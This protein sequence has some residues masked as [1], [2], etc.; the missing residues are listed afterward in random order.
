MSAPPY[1]KLFWGDYHKATRHLTRDQH[2]AYFLLIGE[3]WRLGGALPD[4]DAKLAAWALCTPEEWTAM[5]PIIMDFFALRRG[6]WW[7]DRVREEL[8]VYE[9]TSRKRKEAGKKG[10]SAK[11]G[12]ITGNQEA[13]ASLLPPKPEPEPEPEREEEAKA[14][15]GSQAMPTGS[16]LAEPSSLQPKADPWSRDANFAAFWKAATEQ[17]RKRSSQKQAWAEWRKATT[18]V[19]AAELAASMPRYVAG[20]EDCKRTGGPGLHLWLR[21]RKFEHWIG[22]GT[23]GGE[24]AAATFDGPPAL[25]AS[26]VEVLGE[27]FARSWIDTCVWDAGKRTLLARNAF[28]ASK[29][30][31]ELEGWM[32]KVNVK[33]AVKGDDQ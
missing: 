23:V 12:K 27:A 22:A 33:A 18:V 31:T 6:K 2:G 15:V 30:N 20:D 10:G 13:N 25:R 11:V 21:G 19:P 24:E 5:K 29:L 16:D 32:R 4:E 1:M 26:V 9:S 3:A 28:G 14:S 17:G 8:A 7:H